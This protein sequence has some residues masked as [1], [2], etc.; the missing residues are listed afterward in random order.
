MFHFKHL[1]YLKHIHSLVHD[2]SP[3]GLVEL[4]CNEVCHEANVGHLKLFHKSTLELINSL[5]IAARYHSFTCIRLHI[6][7]M[8]EY[9]FLEANFLYETIHPLVSSSWSLLF[10][11]LYN[12]DSWFLITKPWGCSTYTLSSSSKFKNTDLTFI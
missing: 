3:F 6:H 2:Q 4:N 9:T 11:N 10:F 7:V 8:F 5:F 12:F 1:Q